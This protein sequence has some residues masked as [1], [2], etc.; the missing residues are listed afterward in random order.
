MA[1][2]CGINMMSIQ[3]LTET[4]ASLS[5]EDIKF[6]SSV[7]ALLDPRGNYATLRSKITTFLESNQKITTVY[8][9]VPLLPF[10]GVLLKAFV[11]LDENPSYLDEKSEAV[12]CSKLEM[13]AN[14]IKE[15]VQVQQTPF[16]YFSVKSLQ[17]YLSK[18]YKHV[19]KDDTLL[20]LSKSI[21][22]SCEGG[23]IKRTKEHKKTRSL[24]QIKRK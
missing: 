16:L 18:A 4:W 11:G 2:F 8:S 19:E 5:K 10:H 12:N 24:T 21:E 20:K 3:R 9:R 13:I 1:I 22:S 15:L 6:L 7:E 23:D 17:N 14:Q